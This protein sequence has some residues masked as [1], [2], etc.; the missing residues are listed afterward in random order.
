MDRD[1]ALPNGWNAYVFMDDG[2]AV[3]LGGAFYV[4]CRIVKGGD[5][6]E[7]RR[8]VVLKGKED[9][10]ASTDAEALGESK[11]GQVVT[12]L[13]DLVVME[14]GPDGKFVTTQIQKHGHGIRRVTLSSFWSPDGEMGPVTKPASAP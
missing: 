13:W 12:Q 11:P 10:L 5:P 2:F 6:S 1:F 9:E 14:Q 7:K 4:P 8:L 3:Q